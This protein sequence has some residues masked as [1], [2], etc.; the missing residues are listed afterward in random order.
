VVAGGGAAEAAEGEPT[1]ALIDVRAVQGAT[2]AQGAQVRSALAASLAKYR[3]ELIADHA[4]VRAAYGPGAEAA[5][6]PNV[7]KARLRAK[8][9]KKLFDDLDPAGAEA[10]F[11]QAAD[12]FEA[13]A[14]GLSSPSDLINTYL[15][16]ARVFFST[17]RETLARDIFK[18]VVQIQPELTLDKA[19]YPPGMVSVFEDVKKS[20]LSSPL[21]AFSVA[22]IPSPARVY[23]DGRDR[24]AAPVDLVNIPAGVHTLTLRRPGYAPWVR[25]IDVTTFRVDKIS[26]ELALDRHPALDL[27]F[28]QKGGEQKDASLG[29]TVLDYLDGVAEAAALDVLLVGRAYK[30]DRTLVVE[31]VPF[32]RIDRASEASEEGERDGRRNADQARTTRQLGEMQSLV[33][34]AAPQK[35]TDEFAGRILASLAK[36]EWIPAIAARRSVEAGGGA[37]DETAT[38]GLR[39]SLVPSTRVAGSGKNF[40]NAPGAGFRVGADYRLSGRVLLAVETGFDALAEND[41]LLKDSA[42]NVV[43]SRSQN[44]QALYTSIPLDV[45]ARYYFGVSTLA[46]YASGTLGIRWDQLAF[47]EGLPFDQIKGSSGLGFSASAGGGVD[48]ALG[49]RSALFAE[50]RL[51]VGTIGASDAS[52]DITTTSKNPD[53]KLP[54]DAGTWIGLRLY[55]GYVHVF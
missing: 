19:V 32:R 14:G 5:M 30:K 47:R 49:T 37:I 52:I 18:R 27:V 43:V 55:L 17:E 24:G 11:R 45:G 3:I 38:F 23:L 50:S 20:L 2:P 25:P 21:G 7:E 22:S 15:Y 9:G 53:R 44:V 42:G 33:L 54:V 13:N 51:Q 28:V 1:V 29:T 16:L 36:A 34:T 35:E 39:V 12:L 10:K 48:Y 46:P 8:E 41:V 31:V 26:A 4:A 40:P 6:A